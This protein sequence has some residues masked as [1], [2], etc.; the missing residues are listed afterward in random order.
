MLSYGCTGFQVSRFVHAKDRLDPV[1][2]HPGA[3]ILGLALIVFAEYERRKIA[4]EV[5]SKPLLSKE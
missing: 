5:A 4:K 1:E 3:I 2:L